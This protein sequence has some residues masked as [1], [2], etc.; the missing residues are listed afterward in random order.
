MTATAPRFKNL[1]DFQADQ[2]SWTQR[3][4]NAQVGW[5]EALAP[6]AG[7]FEE[8]G[9]LVTAKGQEDVL[10]QQDAVAD[11]AIYLTDVCNRIEL[12]LL[13]LRFSQ[14]K[15]Y[16]PGNFCIMM[17]KSL[18]SLSHSILKQG[19]KIRMEENHAMNATRH[20]SACFDHL[21]FYCVENWRMSLFDDVVYPVWEKVRER[22][23]TT[24][25]AEHG[26]T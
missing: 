4:F 16:P 10:E 12:P 14:K 17:I 9:E 22:D 11:M 15:P 21:E 6:L 25:R 8:F 18:G 3:N 5:V 13:D 23:W 20:M 7:A 26:S 19:Q 24:E 1:N 2:W